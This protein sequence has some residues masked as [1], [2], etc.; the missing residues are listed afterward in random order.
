MQQS[1]EVMEILGVDGPVEAEFMADVD[2]GL[3][4]GVAAGDLGG[5]IRRQQI[6]QRESDDTDAEQD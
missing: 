2:D 3:G 1:V 6:E 5:R 4:T